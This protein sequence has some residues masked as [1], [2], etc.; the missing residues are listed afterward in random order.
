MSTTVSGST[1]STVG[2]LTGEISIVVTGGTVVTGSALPLPT[3][4]VDPDY[5]Y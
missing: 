3:G 5:P 1:S 4:S 2:E